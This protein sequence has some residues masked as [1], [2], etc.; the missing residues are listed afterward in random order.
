M[1]KFVFK[2]SNL[3]L[4]GPSRRWHLTTG[5]RPQRRARARKVPIREVAHR[6]A[7]TWALPPATGGLKPCH[8]HAPPRRPEQALLSSV[9][10]IAPPPVETSLTKGLT[11][12]EYYSAP[13]V[14]YHYSQYVLTL[15]VA[16]CACRREM[17][18][19]DPSRS[20]GILSN[21]REMT[22]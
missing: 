5:R 10:A 16:K 20:T 11:S 6:P 18:G 8:T 22:H 4:N 7:P 15:V 14:L 1:I 13:A 21:Y 2:Q 17:N 12:A 9:R 3:N 19:C